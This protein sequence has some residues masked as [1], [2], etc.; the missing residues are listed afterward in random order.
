[1]RSVLVPF[2]LGEDCLR[3]RVVSKRLGHHH[4]WYARQIALGKLEGTK[5][6]RDIWITVDAW[7]RFVATCN[8]GDEPEDVPGARSRSE[9]QR[10]IDDEKAARRCEELGC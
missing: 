6:G 4:N 7:E 5:L 1:M 3:G 2:K 9:R 8:P 10:R